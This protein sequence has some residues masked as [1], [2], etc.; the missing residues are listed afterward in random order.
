MKIIKRD[1]REV[2][3]LVD[4]PFKK[5]EKDISLSFHGSRNQ[6]IIYLKRASA[7]GN[8]GNQARNHL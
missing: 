6:R 1:G 3:V 7:G 5:A 2:D 8:C 4:G